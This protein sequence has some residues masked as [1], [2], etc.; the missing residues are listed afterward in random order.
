MTRSDSPP[1][2][3]SALS[4]KL[5]PGVVRGGQALGR[6]V[7]GLD[8]IGVGEGHPAAKGQH[9]DLESGP[10]ESAILHLCH[11]CLLRWCVGVRP[12]DYAG[13]SATPRRRSATGPWAASRRRRRRRRRRRPTSS[14]DN[15]IRRLEE[16]PRGFR[17][18][19]RPIWTFRGPGGRMIAMT[20]RPERTAAVRGEH[21]SP[22]PPRTRGH[23]CFSAAD[24][25]IDVPV[26]RQQP[27]PMAFAKYRATVPARPARPHLARPPTHQG[28]PLVQRRPARRKPG[29]HRSDGP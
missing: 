12:R 26:K 29:P 9:A 2:Y 18:V 21:R 10:P 3:A 7:G 25:R 27:S 8:L 11:G 4:K 16:C 14:K 23:F 1:A 22:S 6:L 5:T 15:L 17:L 19:A 13:R 24:E 20:C 28:A